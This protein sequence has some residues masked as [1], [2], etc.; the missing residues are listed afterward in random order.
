[1]A[2]SIK[3]LIAQA[4]VDPSFKARLVADFVSVAAEEGVELTP[5]QAAAYGKM[6]PDDWEKTEAVLT[7]LIESSPCTIP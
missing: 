7:S 1:M 6:K 5:A 4:I 3:Q 2:S